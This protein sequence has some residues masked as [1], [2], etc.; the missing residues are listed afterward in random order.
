MVTIIRTGNKTVDKTV[1]K[2]IRKNVSNLKGV[3]K[4][5][6]PGLGTIFYIKNNKSETVGHIYKDMSEVVISLNEGVSKC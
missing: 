1:R 2:I 5:Y 6:V 3:L 4:K